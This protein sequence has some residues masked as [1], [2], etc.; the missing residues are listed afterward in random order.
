[1]KRVPDQRHRP[2]FD[3]PTLSSHFFV[4]LL[5]GRCLAAHFQ[6]FISSGDRMNEP[7]SCK[8]PEPP[9]P[10]PPAFISSLPAA[11]CSTG[12]GKNCNMPTSSGFWERWLVVVVF[13][14][15]TDGGVVG[16]SCLQ[17][18]RSFDWITERPVGFSADGHLSIR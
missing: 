4:L 3:L 17:A 8:Q 12:R 10:P 9:P 1:M 7:V 14:G 16:L 15:K 13:E 11:C 2:T 5:A 18:I 6:E